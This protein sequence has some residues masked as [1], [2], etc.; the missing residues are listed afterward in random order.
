MDEDAVSLLGHFP[1]ELE[2]SNIFEIIH[3]QDLTILKDSFE[4][5]VLGRDLKSKPYRMKTRNSDYAIVVT[6]W[7]CFVNPWTNNLEF[8]NGIHTIV[9]GP[10][11]PNIFAEPIFEGPQEKESNET[12]K[13]L[14]FLQDD[15]K[16]LLRHYVRKRHIS[17]RTSVSSPKSKI[18]LSNYLDTLRHKVAKAETFTGGCSRLPQVKVNDS[19]HLSDSS[20]TLPSQNQLRYKENMR[21]FFNSKPRTL[22]IKEI[23]SDILQSSTSGY[24]DDLGDPIRTKEDVLTSSNCG[25]RVDTSYKPPLLTENLLL[26]HN[27]KM[28]VQMVEQYKEARGKKNRKVA[29]LSVDEMHHTDP[30]KEGAFPVALTKDEELPMMPSIQM[31]NVQNLVQ[32]G[33]F[34]D[35]ILD[36]IGSLVSVSNV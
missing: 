33:D 30:K 13:M 8:I 17:D 36:P 3:P 2:G 23:V 20:D 22:L 10:K 25:E 24:S 7:S 19:P 11:N 5:L 29:S 16:L 9:K 34:L 27:Q 18:K 28:E 32:V 12:I 31:D 21:R 35:P 26:L 6:S 15:I 1:S 4:N 14:S